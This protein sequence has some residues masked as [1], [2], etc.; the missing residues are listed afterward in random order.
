M[1]A[2]SHEMAVRAVGPSI[3]TCAETLLATTKRKL[4]RDSVLIGKRLPVLAHETSSR[5]VHNSTSRTDSSHVEKRMHISRTNLHTTILPQRRDPHPLRSLE[6]VRLFA[7]IEVFCSRPDASKPRTASVS[8][9]TR[10]RFLLWCQDGAVWLSPIERL[11]GFVST[12]CESETTDLHYL[13]SASNATLVWC[14]FGK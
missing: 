3:D 12:V 14:S 4:G 13:R 10:H 5:T 8:I 9:H 11:D 1:S 7:T 6:P 2:H